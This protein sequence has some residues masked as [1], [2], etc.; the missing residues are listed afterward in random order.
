MLN[1]VIKG[2][3]QQL[4][5]ALCPEDALQTGDPLQRELPVLPHCR[6]VPGPVPQSPSPLPPH[7]PA[8]FSW[9]AGTAGRDASSARAALSLLL[10]FC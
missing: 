4:Q 7:S 1:K 9:E 5:E 6:T 8:L 2:L 10:T 3:Q